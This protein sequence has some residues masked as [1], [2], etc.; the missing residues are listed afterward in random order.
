MA[1]VYVLGAGA[2]GLSFAHHLSSEHDVTILS[3]NRKTTDFYYQEQTTKKPI[4]ASI[5]NVTELHSSSKRLIKNCFICVKSY[6]LDDAFKAVQPFLHNDANIFLSHNGI[7]E[8]TDI[9]CQLTS[10]QRLFFISTSRGAFK[11][12]LNLVVQ[13]GFGDTYLGACND[14]ASLYI[15]FVFENLLANTIKPSSIHNNMT[16]LRW[17]KLMVNIAINPLTAINQITNGELLKPRYA[18]DVMNLLNE[19]CKVASE[20]GIK[21]SLKDAL[22]NAYTVMRQT[23]EN[24][25]SMAQDVKQQRK[26]EIGAICGYIVN[27]AN[28]LNINVPFNKALLEKINQL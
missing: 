26:T 20:F 25:S 5:I 3:R 4:K 16:L 15:N 17:Q 10:T 24:H 22:D 18:F 11:P 27:E 28:K 13:T 9:L 19:A 6:Q 8:L 12:E 21:I 2:V 23:Y 7:I 1:D 14:E